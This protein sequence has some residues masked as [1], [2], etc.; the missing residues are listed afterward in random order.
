MNW[1]K[2]AWSIGTSIP[3]A[4]SGPYGILVRL[5]LIAAVAG[6]I[7][8]FG[9]AK[10]GEAGEEELEQFRVG[11]DKAHA[12]QLALDAERKRL[13]EALIAEKDS[14][15]DE[16]LRNANLWWAGYFDRMQ[17]DAGR[18]ARAKP[19]PVESK[20]CNDAARD[21]EL[22]LAVRAAEQDLR[23]ATD[24]YQAGIARLLGAAEVQTADLLNLQDTWAR[25]RLI[26][27]GQGRIVQ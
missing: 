10:G 20:I 18:R 4:L 25:E 15:H 24:E 27:G 7:F 23:R 13:S 19:V 6:G 14:Q 11:V 8:L 12:Q 21:H 2:A 16:A 9:Y 26:N 3:S 5:G 22:S 1:L 17:H